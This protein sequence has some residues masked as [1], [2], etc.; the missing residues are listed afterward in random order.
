M[1]EIYDISGYHGILLGLDHCADAYQDEDKDLSRGYLLHRVTNRNRYRHRSHGH[2][3]GMM[4]K[5]GRVKLWLP[6]SMY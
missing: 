5:I 2:G 3:G 1:L 6:I 4:V